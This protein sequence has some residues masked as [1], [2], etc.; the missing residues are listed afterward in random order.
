[1][2]RDAETHIQTL[3]GALKS[4]GRVWGRIMGPE[5]DSDSTG[6]PTKST[7]LDPWGCPETESSTKE[8]AGA[9]PRPPTHM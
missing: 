6:K 8:L 3:A 4:Y 9:G 7:N 5:E 1:M 2:E